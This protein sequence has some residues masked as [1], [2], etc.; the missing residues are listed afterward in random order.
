MRKCWWTSPRFF[1]S[2]G[3]ASGTAYLPDIPRSSTPTINNQTTNQPN[4]NIGNTIRIYTNRKSTSFTHKVY[5]NYGETQ[6]EIAT[7]VTDYYDYDTSTIANDLYSL[8]PNEKSYSG[9][10]SLKTYSGTTQIGTEKSC[11]YIANVVNSDPV[12]TDFV[13]EDVNT[14]TTTLTGNNKYNINNYS[15]IKATI[16]VSNKA[17]AVNGAEMVMYRFVIGND[18]VDIPYNSSESVSGTINKATTGIYTVYAIDSRGN[19]TAVI[20]QATSIINYAELTRTTNPSSK[21]NT[22]VGEEYTLNYAGTIW[23]QSFG[24]LIN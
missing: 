4:F 1:Q 8:I 7:D 9:T 21:R 12:F 19:S 10:I 13:F 15:N 24:S 17:S 2:S 20:K 3:W 22:G 18:S 23:N 16:S 6:L 5:F 14:T 11:A